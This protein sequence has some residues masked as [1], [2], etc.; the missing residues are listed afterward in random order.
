MDWVFKKSN[1]VQ[2]SHTYFPLSKFCGADSNFSKISAKHAR[3]VLIGQITLPAIRGKDCVKLP[4]LIL[5]LL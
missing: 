2:G 3:R 4:K 1:A 5:L